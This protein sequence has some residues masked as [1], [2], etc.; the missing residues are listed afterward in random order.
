MPLLAMVAKAVVKSRLVTPSVSPPRAVAAF[1][2]L[3]VKVVMP[4]FLAY[5]TPSCGITVSIRQR[6][7]TIFME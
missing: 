1:K 3:L 6:T 4:I 2:S 7:A 5:S